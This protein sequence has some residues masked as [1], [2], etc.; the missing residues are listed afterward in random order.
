MHSTSNLNDGYIGSGKYLKR[1]I[2]KYGKENFKMEILEFLTDRK[3]L[4]EREKVLVCEETINDLEC[5]NLKTGGTGG[6][7]G[8]NG[9]H[10]GGDN[11]KNARLYWEKPENK[12]KLKK[13]ASDTFKKLWKNGTLKYVNNWE[14]KNHSEDSKK[15]IGESNSIKQKGELNSQFGTCWITN[16]IENKKI[17]KSDLHF[18]NKWR[19]GRII[20]NG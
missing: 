13:R 6:N 14:G 20:K 15:K 12:E 16:G 4:K 1:S 18:Y 10:L 11:F 19:L 2:N 8:K 7:L 5:M 17:K 9:K 3:S